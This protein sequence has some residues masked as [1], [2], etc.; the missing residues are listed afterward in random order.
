MDQQSEEIKKFKARFDNEEKEIL[1]L[2]ESGM[3]ASKS[4]NEQYWTVSITALAYI[5]MESGELVEGKRRIEW[6]ADDKERRSEKKIYGLE[7]QKIYQLVVK[8]SLPFENEYTHDIFEKGYWLM[9]VDVA[10]RNC[11][12]KQLENILKEYQKEVFI[13]PKG[14]ETLVLDKSLGIFSG[15]GIWNQKECSIHL[16]SDGEDLETANEA[17]ITFNE[18]MTHCDIW[19]QKAREYAADELTEL[20]NDWAEE[21]D[22]EITHEDFARRIL[23]SE[24]CASP[25]GD[26]ELFYEDDDMFYGHVI[27]VSGNIHEGFD[28]ADIAG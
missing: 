25:E 5:D 23:I 7:G 19:D 9:L 6:L 16:D 3:S 21:D 17:L 24:V 2:T 4:G 13:Q 1:V 22:S 20:A 11:Q 12:N 14:C 27:I 15:E 8:E 18:L 26:F 10:K 28:G